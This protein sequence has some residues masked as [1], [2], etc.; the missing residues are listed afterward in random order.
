M[1]NTKILSISNVG[2]HI[3]HPSTFDLVWNDGQIELTVKKHFLRQNIGLHD[4]PAFG[5]LRHP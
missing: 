5:E 2:Q 3:E 1:V 4:W